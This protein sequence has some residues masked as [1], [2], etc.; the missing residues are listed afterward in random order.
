MDKDLI[1]QL[2]DTLEEIIRNTE[3]TQEEKTKE[4]EIARDKCIK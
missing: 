2:E 3:L 4:M 1:A